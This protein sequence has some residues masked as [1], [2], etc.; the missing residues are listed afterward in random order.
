MNALKLEGPEDYALESES[1]W[2]SVKGVSVY[3]Q[4]TPNGVKVDLY[5]KGLEA[6]SDS[7][8]TAEILDEEVQ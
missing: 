8:A 3:I 1:V 7:L 4:N 5:P 2:I 6:N